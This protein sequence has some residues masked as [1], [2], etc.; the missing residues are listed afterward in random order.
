MGESR[1]EHND[2]F[3]LPRIERILVIRFID[4]F[5]M[6][7]EMSASTSDVDSKTDTPDYKAIAVDALRVC[8]EN[9]IKLIS[10]N[11]WPTLTL[12]VS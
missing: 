1:I 9:G 4:D 7:A 8:S 11:L 6:A 10:S 5:A 3:S 2:S 12:R